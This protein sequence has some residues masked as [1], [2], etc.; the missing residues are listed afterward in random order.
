M[1]RAILLIVDCDMLCT[2]LHLHKLQS[3]DQYNY[4]I[5][6]NALF[7][8]KFVFIPAMRYVVVGGR[9]CEV[10]YASGVYSYLSRLWRSLVAGCPT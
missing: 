1:P 10:D 6:C 2:A 5:M 9:L 7:G 4:D 8:F 3:C